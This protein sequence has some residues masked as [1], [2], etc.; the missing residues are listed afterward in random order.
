MLLEGTVQSTL[1][2][3]RFP[4]LVCLSVDNVFTIVRLAF[5]CIENWE[6]VI[7]SPNVLLEMKGI[8][9]ERLSKSRQVTHTDFKI[10]RGC[11]MSQFVSYV[12]LAAAT[13]QYSDLRTIGEHVHNCILSCVGDVE[14]N[15]FLSVKKYLLKSHSSLATVIVFTY[16]VKNHMNLHNFSNAR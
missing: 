1:A 13:C 4:H 2:C 11:F 15:V 5:S 3:H 10:R 6:V 12:L 7:C 14:G 9:K 16:C 8:I